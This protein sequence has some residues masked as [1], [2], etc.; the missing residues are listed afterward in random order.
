MN[1]SFVN[2]PEAQAVPISSIT[3][4]FSAAAGFL[5][6]GE[7]ATWNRVLGALVVVL[8]VVVIFLI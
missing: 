6:F 5:L 8:G 3:P 2:I 7:K 4:L 1:Y